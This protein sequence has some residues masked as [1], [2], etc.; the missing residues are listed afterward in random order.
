MQEIEFI[1]VFDEITKEG[2]S[3]MAINESKFYFQKI[4]DK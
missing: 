1:K 4:L 3:L 2:Y